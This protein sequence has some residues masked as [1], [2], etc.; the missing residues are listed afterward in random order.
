MHSMA[1]FGAKADYYIVLSLVM[2]P[3][4]LQASI[5]MVST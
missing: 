5:I 2:K 4:M 1:N 3:M